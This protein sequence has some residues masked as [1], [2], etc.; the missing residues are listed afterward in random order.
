MRENAKAPKASEKLD[1]YL[2]FEKN[3]ILQ[4]LF[5]ALQKHITRLWRNKTSF[6]SWL[7]HCTITNGMFWW[8]KK[9]H[10]KSWKINGKIPFLAALLH[11][12]QKISQGSEN[13]NMLAPGRRRMP[14][15]CCYMLPSNEGST[16][17][18][19]S[20]IICIN[21]LHDE[22]FSSIPPL[23]NFHMRS[24]PSINCYC[25][26]GFSSSSASKGFFEQRPEKDFIV[27]VTKQWSIKL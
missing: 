14:S 4:L 27:V 18:T 24:G 11:T 26:M 3:L 23:P 8:W 13:C 25:L 1:C 9:R 2:L 5:Q 19:F 21:Y 7:L 6:L 22:C 17:E 20:M 10:T 15:R 16:I 12:P